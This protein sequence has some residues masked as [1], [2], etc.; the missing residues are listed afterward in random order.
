MIE[1]SLIDLGLCALI[2]ICSLYFLRGSQKP[3]KPASSSVQ[4]ASSKAATH[5][6]ASGFLDKMQRLKKKIVIFYGSQT[7]TAEGYACQLAKEG[8]H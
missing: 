8:F 7:G 6:S 3:V 4:N 5:Y 1:F 2:I